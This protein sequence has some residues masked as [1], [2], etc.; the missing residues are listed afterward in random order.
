MNYSHT[1]G[2]RISQLALGTA[3]LGLPY[4]IAN[5][6][7]QP[8]DGTARRILQLALDSG[9][10]TFDTAPAY[11]RSE[12]II[13]SFLARADSAWR[14]DRLVIVTKLP[15]VEANGCPSSQM[16][17]ERVRCS[18]R[19][20]AKRLHLDRVPIC[21]MHSAE[22][23]TKCGG[24]VTKSLVRLKEEG[25][26]EKIGVSVYRPSEV[27]EFLSIGG[28]D[29]IQIPVNLFD[30]RLI[31]GGHLGRLAGSG[32]IVFARSV[33]LQGLFFLE[34][35]ELPPF[36]HMAR[37]P[38]LAL[39]RLSGQCSR[40]VAELAVAFVRDLPAITSLVIG[41][42]TVAQLRENVRLVNSPPLGDSVRKSLHGLFGRLPEELINPATWDE[43]RAS[44]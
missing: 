36:L 25:L 40:P 28:L 5:R 33:F 23:M 37:E 29:A 20:S 4:G 32:A 7:G 34:P 38:L 43:R 21:L 35:E 8:S 13:G 39:R 26:V 42:E 10:N 22:D 2:L 17:Y 1:G 16:I 19:S 31:H 27:A 18:L 30:H 6:T 3:Q 11:G 12:S 44:S 24:L 9:I 14:S 15:K 41:A